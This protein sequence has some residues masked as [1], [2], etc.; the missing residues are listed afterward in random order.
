MWKQKTSQVSIFGGAQYIFRGKDFYFYYMFKTNVFRGYKR[1]F[2]GT[3]PESPLVALMS[4]VK[5]AMLL[6]SQTH[7]YCV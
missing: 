6:W 3:A 2:E 4:N 7:N 1:N 5:D